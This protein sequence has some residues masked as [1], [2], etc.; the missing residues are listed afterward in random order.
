MYEDIEIKFLRGVSWRQ[1]KFLEWGWCVGLVWRQQHTW[2]RAF[3]R[4]GSPTHSHLRWIVYINLI[5]IFLGKSMLCPRFIHW[6]SSFKGPNRFALSQSSL[7]NSGTFQKREQ[8]GRSQPVSLK[9]S[10]TRLMTESW[11]KYLSAGPMAWAPDSRTG[12]TTLIFLELKKKFCFM[13]NLV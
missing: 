5:W 8:E 4:V 13:S 2:D 9:S 1:E 6:H 3:R 12:A 7:L 11:S 10:W